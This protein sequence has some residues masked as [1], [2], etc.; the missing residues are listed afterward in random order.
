MRAGR[1]GLEVAAQHPAFAA[2]RAFAL[3]AALDHA[4]DAGADCIRHN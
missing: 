2:V 1:G 3:Q 4:A